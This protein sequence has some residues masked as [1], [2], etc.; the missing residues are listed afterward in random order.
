[1]KWGNQCVGKGAEG[2]VITLSECSY[3]ACALVLKEKLLPLMTEMVVISKPLGVILLWRRQ[4]NH[5][6][7]EPPFPVPHPLHLQ[8]L[9]I[10]PLFKNKIIYR[11]VTSFN[12]WGY[13]RPPFPHA[14]THTYTHNM[15]PSSFHVDIMNVWAFTCLLWYEFSVLEKITILLFERH[16]PIIKILVNDIS[17]P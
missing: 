4:K 1:M 16:K 2:I 11:H 6:F 8:K 3:L 12:T 7:C 14:N 17:K 13:P 5:Q 10:E 9:K 15:W